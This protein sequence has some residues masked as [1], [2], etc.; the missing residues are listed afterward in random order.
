[1]CVLGSAIEQFPRDLFS[2][3]PLIGEDDPIG[4]SG[5]GVHC[6][7]RET[8]RSLFVEHAHERRREEYEWLDVN[9]PK[10]YDDTDEIARDCVFYFVKSSGRIAVHDVAV[11]ASGIFEELGISESTLEQA[12]TAALN[13]LEENDYIAF[14]GDHVMCTSKFK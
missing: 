1:M 11:Y 12:I 5:F 8:L 3:M 9:V 7:A 13:W 10:E 4:R 6:A 14:E 2:K